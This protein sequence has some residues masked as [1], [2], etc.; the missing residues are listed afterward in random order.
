MAPCRKKEAFNRKEHKDLR[1]IATAWFC[2]SFWSLGPFGLLGWFAVRGWEVGS[3]GAS[4][5]RVCA[6]V[7]LGDF[8]FRRHCREYDRSGI[9]AEPVT[10]QQPTPIG[11]FDVVFDAGLVLADEEDFFERRCSIGCK[12][13]FSRYCSHGE[14]KVIGG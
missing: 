14:M 7:N 2:P 13:F 8:E 1:A 9:R 10:L 12:L 6:I 11:L 5:S 3:D 4:P